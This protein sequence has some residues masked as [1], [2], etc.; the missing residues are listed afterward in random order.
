[1]NKKSIITIGIDS[2]EN[3]EMLEFLKTI[4]NE[5]SSKT[6]I[7]LTFND[8]NEMKYLYNLISN[9]LTIS[10]IESVGDNPIF[11][12]EVNNLEDDKKIVEYIKDSTIIYSLIGVRLY[13]E[14]MKKNNSVTE[15]R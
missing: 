5:D 1:M 2:N 6:V 15:E 11:K 8:S 13:D 4:F 14:D 12:M 9:N 7:N 10:E 3:D